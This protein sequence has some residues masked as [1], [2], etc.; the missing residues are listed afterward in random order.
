ML[1]CRLVSKNNIIQKVEA[2][3]KKYCK[4]ELVKSGYQDQKLWLSNLGWLRVS[5]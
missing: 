2:F 1:K 3:A 4:D 5:F